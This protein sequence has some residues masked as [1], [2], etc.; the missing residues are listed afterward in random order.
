MTKIDLTQFDENGFCV[1]YEPVSDERLE[2]IGFRNF[3]PEE[4]REGIVDEIRN[5]LKE[6]NLTI[7]ESWDGGDPGLG[8]LYKVMPLDEFEM[9]RTSTK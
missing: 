6:H 5:Q 9:G 4:F 1:M 2:D 3:H 7:L 8:M